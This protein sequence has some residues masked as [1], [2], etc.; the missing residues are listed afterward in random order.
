MPHLVLEVLSSAVGGNHAMRQT[1]VYFTHVINLLGRW[2]VGPFISS[3][4]VT[5]SR[6]GGQCEGALHWSVEPKYTVDGV[7]TQRCACAGASMSP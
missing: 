7:T 1:I 6:M 4:G 5:G 3:C 2:A